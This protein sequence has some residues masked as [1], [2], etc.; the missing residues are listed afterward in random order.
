MR[1]GVVDLKK[2]KP[3]TA[4]HL[5]TVRNPNAKMVEKFRKLFVPRDVMFHD[6]RALR[7]IRLGAA[8]QA[9]MAGVAA[10]TIA[11]SSYGAAQAGY[12]AVTATGLIADVSPEARLRRMEAEVA[13]LEADVQAA[14]RQARAHAARVEKRQAVIAAALSGEVDPDSV[15]LPEAGGD[16][17]VSRISAEV[18]APLRRV[19]ARQVVYAAKARAAIE[20]R[21]QA[22]AQQLRRM[23][24]RPER[25][26]G[27]MG[28]PFEAVAAPAGTS[29]TEADAEAQFRSLFQSWKKLDT[30]EEAVIA[31]PS[32]QPV[33]DLTLTSNFGVRSDP[34]RGTAAMHSG[35]DIPGPLGTPIYA[36][37]DGIVAKSERSGG[38]GNMI[39]INHGKGIATRYGH[40][41][42]LMVRPN[43]RVRRGQ[44][45][46]LMGSTGRSTGSHLHYEVRIDGAAVDPIPYLRSGDH[47]LALQDRALRSRQAGSIGGP[48]N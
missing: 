41:S 31:I 7:R 13:A 16:V 46:G 29:A 11:F 40:L 5:P 17:R 37:A 28:G 42:K 38:Y 48:A 6:G 39:E 20:A 36:T 30:L 3:A 24:I 43:T 14:K 47:L 32:L 21:Y 33:E 35:I 23:G 2:I 10:V 12:H 1:V 9:V 27:A 22:T 4:K 45:I 25:L 34:F 26:N 18:T 15:E 44:I 19:E 8:S